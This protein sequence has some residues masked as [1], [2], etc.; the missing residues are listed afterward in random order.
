MAG[1][2]RAAEHDAP[3]QEMLVRGLFRGEVGS[4]NEGPKLNDPAPDFTLKTRDGKATVRLSDHFGKKPIVLVFGN[5]TCGPFRGIYPRVDDLALRYKD[6]AVFL[7][8]YVREAHP[9]DGWRMGSNDHDGMSF[10]QPRDFAERSTLANRCYVKLKMNM[11]LLVD[12]MD[13]RVGHAYSGMPAR[14]YVIDRDGKVAYKGGRGPFGF[15]PDEMEQSLAMLLLDQ[16]KAQSPEPPRTLPMKN[17]D[18]WK[19]L[20]AAEK[21]A[22]EP[23]PSWARM[24]ADALPRTTAAM[25][26]LDYLHRAGGPLDPPLRGRMRW[27]AAHANRCAYG[28]AYAAADL[29]RAGVDEAAIKALVGAPSGWPE[30]ERAALAFARRL[31]LEADAVTDEEVADLI[32]RY[33]EK[34]VVAMVLL[35][36]YA[37]FQD[38][39]LLTLGLPLEDGGP[40]PPL[41]VRFTPGGNVPAPAPRKVPAEPAA[42]PPQKSAGDDWGALGFGDL[43]GL[44]EEQRARPPRIAVPA[45]EDV[46][47]GLPKDYPANR[48]TRIKWS[49][50][51]LGY[52]PEL[53]AAW[54][55]CM[56]TFGEESKQDRVFEESLFWVVTR[57][58]RCFY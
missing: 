42:K 33:G 36:A 40:L 41:D 38:R 6:E 21:G 57:S 22:G 1:P 46:L 50:V 20:P 25:L 8:V 16:H 4:M 55:R 11:P 19:R 15:K 49:L 7:A 37:N 23:L 29:R 31:T 39:L 51:C 32:K 27:V 14:L 47:R 3:T 18:A 30:K 54:L 9:T 43:R 5:V 48:P 2:P 10:A 58:L 34:Q 24:L 45:W 52:Q 12:E 26:E 56:R 35:L 44:L 53:S 28:E 13:D 17:A